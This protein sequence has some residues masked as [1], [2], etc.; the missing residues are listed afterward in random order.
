V[1]VC[2]P[3]PLPQVRLSKVFDVLSGMMSDAE[4]EPTADCST[5]NQQASGG[6][7]V[8]DWGVAHATLEE[9]FIKL[10]RSLGATAGD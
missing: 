10:A 5:T 4:E 3:L 8:L 6:V 7:K 1:P 2:L 9:A